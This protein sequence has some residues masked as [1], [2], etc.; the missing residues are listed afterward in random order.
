MILT[1][2]N[3]LMSVD[4]FKTVKILD[5]KKKL[6]VMTKYILVKQVFIIVK[7]LKFNAKSKFEV[8]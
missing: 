5:R 1:D 4:I 2:K 6:L 8:D 7:L 3:T